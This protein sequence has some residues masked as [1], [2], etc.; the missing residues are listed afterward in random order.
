M[1]VSAEVDHAEAALRLEVDS[2]GGV[3]AGPQA[4]L[5]RRLVVSNLRSVQLAKDLLAAQGE[6]DV[7]Q[8]RAAVAIDLAAESQDETDIDRAMRLAEGARLAG[9]REFALSREWA[10]HRSAVYELA[11]AAEAALRSNA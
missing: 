3:A 2:I 10:L 7:Q 4:D 1:L 11:Q 5:I 8:T 6:V 9:R